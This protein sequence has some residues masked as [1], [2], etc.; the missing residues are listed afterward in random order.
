MRLLVT[1]HCGFIGQNF[2]RM[3]HK[4]HYIVG[5]DKMGYASD[6]EAINFCAKHIQ[7]DIGREDFDSIFDEINARYGPFDVIVNF[8]AESHVDNSIKSPGVFMQ[9]NIIGAFNLL[10]AARKHGVKRFIQI[11]TDEVYGDLNPEDP[12]FSNLHEMKPSSP[13]SASKAAADLLALSYYKTFGMDVIITRS[14]NNYGP[15]QH[16][17]KFIP[18][19]ITKSLRNEEIPIYGTGLNMREWIYVEDN[20]EGVMKAIT[21]GSPG[22]IYN[23]GSG[24]EKTNID[25]V[26]EIL[27]NL[28][29][30]L[31]LITMVED[32]RGHDFRYFLDSQ[33]TYN[34]LNWNPHT[35]FSKGLNKTISYYESKA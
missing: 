16:Q 34:E 4:E 18:V 33:D 26:E 35:P 27:C 2:V 1:G 12:P 23:L 11:G 10:E 9:S 7:L 24:E 25:L 6:K 5:I 14:C 15:F 29:R 3:F 30:P 22:S 19:I 8:A 28:E 21:D 17:E 31:S 13:Y 20:C 32:R